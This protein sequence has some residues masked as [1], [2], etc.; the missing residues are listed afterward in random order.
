MADGL[1]AS[2][3]TQIE[4]RSKRYIRAAAGYRGELLKMPKARLP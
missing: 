1:M 4:I 3:I 2:S